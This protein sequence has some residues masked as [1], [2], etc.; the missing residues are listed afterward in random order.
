MFLQNADFVCSSGAHTLAD[1]NVLLG[2]RGGLEPGRFHMVAVPRELGHAFGAF[3][4]MIGVSYYTRHKLRL[5][6]Q[7]AERSFIAVGGLQLEDL[8]ALE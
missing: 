8:A 4:H 5:Q 7:T 2:E 1:W 3:M 6:E